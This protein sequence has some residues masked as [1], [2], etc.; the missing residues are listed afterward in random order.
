MMVGKLITAP[1]KKLLPNVQLF[2]LENTRL[3]QIVHGLFRYMML[4][5]KDYSLPIAAEGVIGKSESTP[6]T[7]KSPLSTKLRYSVTGS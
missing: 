5:E 4:K 6:S 3:N 7:E 2:K 1:T